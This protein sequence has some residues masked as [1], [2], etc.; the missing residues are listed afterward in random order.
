ML[1]YSSGTAVILENTRKV[2]KEEGKEYREKSCTWGGHSIQ[3]RNPKISWPGFYVVRNDRA[4][5]KLSKKVL[6]ERSPMMLRRTQGLQPSRSHSQEQNFKLSE[7][8][9]QAKIWELG[10][11]EVKTGDSAPPQEMNFIHKTARCLYIPLSRRK[12]LQLLQMQ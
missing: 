1:M 12:R 3:Q 8:A 6:Y 2:A 10:G 11:F 9:F 7:T 4:R 5:L